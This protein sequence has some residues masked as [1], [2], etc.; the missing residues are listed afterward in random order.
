MFGSSISKKPEESSFDCGK[1][2]TQDHNVDIC[3][4]HGYINPFS[5][6]VSQDIARIFMLCADHLKM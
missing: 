4:L 6:L 5:S 1:E 3:S 2:G